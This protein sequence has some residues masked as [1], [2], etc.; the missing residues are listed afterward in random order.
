MPAKILQLH[1]LNPDPDDQVIAQFLFTT[2]RFLHPQMCFRYV[3]APG[4]FII[5]IGGKLVTLQ[6]LKVIQKK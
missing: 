3:P 4:C 1:L 6:V 2:V 5:L